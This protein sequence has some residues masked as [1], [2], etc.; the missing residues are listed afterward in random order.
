MTK[1][2]DRTCVY[3]H[4]VLQKEKLFPRSETLEERVL[5]SQIPRQ[6]CERR[7]SF[8]NDMLQRSMLIPPTHFKSEEHGEKIWGKSDL[9]DS[10]PS[11]NNIPLSKSLFLDILVY[12]YVENYLPLFE[13]LTTQPLMHKLPQVYSSSQTP[14]SS[15]EY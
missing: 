8:W 15:D 12:S 3:L 11:S 13:P 4:Q 2:F 7:F 1:Y 10:C 6:H 9:N 5:L 14:T